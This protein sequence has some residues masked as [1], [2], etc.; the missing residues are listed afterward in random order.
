M[1]FIFFIFTA[2]EARPSDF[3]EI[4]AKKLQFIDRVTQEKLSIEA[5]TI[6]FDSKFNCLDTA[7]KV[8]SGKNHSNNDYKVRGEAIETLATQI[9]K[10]PKSGPLNLTF[11][12]AGVCRSFEKCSVTMS[13]EQFLIS[14]E[15]VLISFDYDPE[16]SKSK[17][18]MHHDAGAQSRAEIEAKMSKL[19]TARKPA[20]EYDWK[21]LESE[22]LQNRKK[23][24]P[25][26]YSEK[27]LAKI[28]LAGLFCTQD[29]Q[30]KINECQFHSCLYRMD[31]MGEKL[32]SDIIV[33]GTNGAGLCAISGPVG[34]RYF[35][36]KSELPYF[37]EV[38]IA[39]LKAIET[40]DSPT[41]PVD[42]EQVVKSK[43]TV[44]VGGVN[45]VMNLETKKDILSGATLDPLAPEACRDKKSD[46]LYQ[47]E[48]KKLSLTF[49]PI[50]MG[51]P[52]QDF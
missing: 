35:V 17:R 22:F 11:Q 23:A 10:M 5:Y 38:L 41:L 37:Y 12:I 6:S 52:K 20:E 31:V 27:T 49:N 4:P 7:C 25:M 29:L 30:L 33:H 46:L 47:L 42:P 45:C 34:K 40:T 8:S 14:P 15:P 1:T 9:P 24:S 36:A 39:T 16:A 19:L 51:F 26:V 43:N 28:N 48:L 21:K 18:R 32:A 50:K 2:F 3:F 13:L 44:Q